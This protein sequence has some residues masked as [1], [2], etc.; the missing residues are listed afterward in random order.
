M[1]NIFCVS[2]CRSRNDD[3]NGDNDNDFGSRK[4]LY[5]KPVYIDSVF[6]VTEKSYQKQI[7]TDRNQQQ[8]NRPI[9]VV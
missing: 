3:Q 9:L 8:Q 6:L 2:G 5:S 1:N 4:K 7:L